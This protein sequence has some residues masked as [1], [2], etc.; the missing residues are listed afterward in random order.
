MVSK[1]DLILLLTELEE[2]GVD[3][4]EQLRKVFT[5]R[6]FPFD[7]LRFINEQRK[8]DITNFYQHLRKSYN[9]KKSKLYINIMKEVTDVNEVL[10]TLSALNLQILLFSKNVGDRHLF[11]NHARADEIVK[12]LSIYYE[13]FDL[14]KCQKLLKLIKADISA[15]E[16][17]DGRRNLQSD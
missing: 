10:T 4:K 15:F 6:E 16:Y 11:L 13:T 17:I 9:Q 8:L 7:V 1:N 14:T 5:T 3:T 12:V 2:Q